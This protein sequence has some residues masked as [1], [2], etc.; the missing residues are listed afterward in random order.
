MVTHQMLHT[1]HDG[2]LN[3]CVL[4]IDGKYDTCAQ[5]LKRYIKSMIKHCI[6]DSMANTKQK[7]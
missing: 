4:L 7:K 5:E 1:H 3:L 6:F 2:G